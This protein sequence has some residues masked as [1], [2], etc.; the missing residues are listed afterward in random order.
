MTRA[1]ASGRC[2]ASLDT[3]R[4]LRRVYASVTYPC[5]QVYINSKA[6][7]PDGRKLPKKDCVEEP[8]LQEIMDVLT[9][10]EFEYIIEVRL[11]ALPS[12]RSL[13]SVP[14]VHWAVLFGTGQD[15]PSRHCAAWAYSRCA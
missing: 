12:F 2:E 1:S 6:S 3:T 13:P 11:A 9:H 4:Y 15:V 10:L 5:A 14:D 7:I 8:Q